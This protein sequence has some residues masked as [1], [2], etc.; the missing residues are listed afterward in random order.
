MNS[1]AQRAFEASVT[2]AQLAAQKQQSLA[3]LLA[4]AMSGIGGSMSRIVLA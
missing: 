2:N 4:N 3:A 1:N